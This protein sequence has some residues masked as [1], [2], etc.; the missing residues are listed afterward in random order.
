MTPK[1]IRE[2]RY[3]LG[4]SQNELG[5][6]LDVSR[7]TIARWE[8]GEIQPE[9]PRMLE[10]ALSALTTKRRKIKIR[11]KIRKLET[12]VRRIQTNTGRLLDEMD[13]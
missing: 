1:E 6:L 12:D 7:N 2:A 10:L 11:Q 9:H 4:L 8:R 3:G 5:E 13:A